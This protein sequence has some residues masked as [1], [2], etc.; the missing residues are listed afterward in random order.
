MCCALR[1]L[2]Y[3]RDIRD[4]D[5][6]TEKHNNKKLCSVIEQTETRQEIEK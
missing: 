5:R 1:Y 3:L 4:G 6:D 2:L